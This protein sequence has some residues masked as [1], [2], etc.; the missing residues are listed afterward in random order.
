MANLC[1]QHSFKGDGNL[2]I[3]NEHTDTFEAANIIWSENSLM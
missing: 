1:D 2:F 3:F